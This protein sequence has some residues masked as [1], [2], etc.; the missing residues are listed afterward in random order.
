MGMDSAW[1]I[2]L[3]ERVGRLS[4][5]AALS[6][7]LGSTGVVCLVLRQGPVSLGVPRGSG[8]SAGGREGYSMF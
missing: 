6:V 3:V 8:G 2:M 1:R 7:I 5:L 4:A